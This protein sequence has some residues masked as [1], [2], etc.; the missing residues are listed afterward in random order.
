[1]ET[2][3]KKKKWTLVMKISSGA[4]FL[5]LRPRTLAC[6]PRRPLPAFPQ[7]PAVVP[8]RTEAEGPSRRRS[9]RFQHRVFCGVAARSPS[10]KMTGQV[11]V[12]I[13]A[14]L[15][16]VSVLTLTCPVIA[17]ASAEHVRS[18]ARYW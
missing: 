8:G 18:K 16:I 7:V 10:A 4:T 17:T 5:T 1:M 14:I 15:A 9:A 12:S 6:A 11:R 3:T 13:L 2:T